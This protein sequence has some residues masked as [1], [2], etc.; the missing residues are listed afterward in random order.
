MIFL[1]AAP[2]AIHFLASSPLIDST[3]ILSIVG[4]V[5]GISGL[6]IGGLTTWWAV[7]RRNSGEIK[8][9]LPE[10]LWSQ[11]ESLRK[12]AIHDKER[13][14][15]QRD[16]I[17]EQ[18]DSLVSAFEGQVVPMLTS[19]NSILAKQAETINEVL[20]LLKASG[21]LPV[22]KEETDVAL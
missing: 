21:P 19:T 18:R 22:T 20:T 3:G 5:V 8:T 14:E 17:A 9:S 10:T 15:E 4:I 2:V 13:A 7:K 11:A 12:D 16:K 6:L 1:L